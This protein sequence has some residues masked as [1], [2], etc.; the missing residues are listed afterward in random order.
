MQARFNH[1]YALRSRNSYSLLSLLP[2]PVF[3]ISLIFV[4]LGMSGCASTLGVEESERATD[5][6][7]TMSAP[8]TTPDT[9]STNDQQ[10]S[11]A[12]DEPA[13]APAG[14]KVVVR[15]VELEPTV[16]SGAPQAMTEEAQDSGAPTVTTGAQSAYRDP[17]MR[18]NRWM[19]NFNDVSYRYVL[20]PVATGYNR[21]MPAPVSTGVSNFFFNIKMPIR[22]F[23]HLLQARPKESGRNL[24]RFGI[25]TTV[26]VLGLFDPAASHFGIEKQDTNS[27]ATLSHYGMRHGNYLV[28]P[29]L[30]SADVRAGGGLIFDYLMN[31][32]RLLEQPES[33]IAMAYNYF[34]TFSP[35]A[36]RY[37]ELR[38][39]SEDPYIFFRNLYLQGV[40]RD[41]IYGNDE[42]PGAAGDDDIE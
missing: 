23:N 24:L 26:G 34:H 36:E 32:L 2:W 21:I 6:R 7:Q 8:G 11:T 30:G 38:N 42:S 22:F 18:W 35:S 19:F 5:S 14:D 13:A 15:G 16:V 4:Q 1:E 10:K 25:N 31:P 33:S 12:V 37:L 40:E 39:Q 20:I 28:L 17:L 27:A 41:E 29:L 3:A 9:E